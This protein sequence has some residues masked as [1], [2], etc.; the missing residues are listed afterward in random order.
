[1]R[2]ADKVWL[3]ISIL[4]L[5]LGLYLYLDENL[6]QNSSESLDKLPPHSYGQAPNAHAD[7]RL[8]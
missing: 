3:K 2:I 8:H 1:M 4:K 7:P 5:H 6:A